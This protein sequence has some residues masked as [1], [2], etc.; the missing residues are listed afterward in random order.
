MKTA[1]KTL[2]LTCDL[3]EKGY[4][5][6]MLSDSSL[7]NGKINRFTDSRIDEG[8]APGCSPGILL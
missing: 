3:A 1:V 7:F 6:L 4:R 2:S 5:E 8:A